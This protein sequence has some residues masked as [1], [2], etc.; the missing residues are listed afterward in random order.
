MSSI[1]ALA[2]PGRV[3][4]ERE[5]AAGVDL[6]PRSARSASSATSSRLRCDCALEPGLPRPRLS[7][8]ASTL[9]STASPRWGVVAT[10]VFVALGFPRADPGYRPCDHARN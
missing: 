6:A 8:T 9:G 4:G 5:G 1:V 10:A 3:L 7:P 2:M